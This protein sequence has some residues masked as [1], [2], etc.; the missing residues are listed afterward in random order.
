MRAYR[1]E[2]KM[3]KTKIYHIEAKDDADLISKHNNNEITD[4]GKLVETIEADV[5]MKSWTQM[6]MEKINE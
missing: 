6:K 2:L 1:I 5:I 3:S 4:K